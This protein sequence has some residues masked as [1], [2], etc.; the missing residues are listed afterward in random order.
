MKTGTVY[1]VLDPSNH[2]L[3]LYVGQTTTP[4]QRRMSRHLASAKQGRRRRFYDVLREFVDTATRLP[5]QVL[6]TGIPLTE[7]DEVEQFYIRYLAERGHPLLNKE[8]AP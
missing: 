2:R 3:C 5:V 1:G 8:V 6:L 4:V 7:L